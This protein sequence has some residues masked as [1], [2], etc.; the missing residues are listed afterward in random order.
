MLLT[1]AGSIA[2]RVAYT[3]RARTGVVEERKK[4]KKNRK[5]ICRPRVQLRNT[6][7]GIVAT[8]STMQ[9]KVR[10]WLSLG[11]FPQNSREWLEKLDLYQKQMYYK[12]NRWWYEAQTQWEYLITGKK[13][14]TTA[15][16]PFMV[17]VVNYYTNKVNEC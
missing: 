4:Q 17:G 9:E 3:T 16:V 5:L 8:Q 12:V 10:R 1:T 14:E 2:A 7:P 11:G 6:L 15:K 13:R